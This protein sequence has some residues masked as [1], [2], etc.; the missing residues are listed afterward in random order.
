[1]TVQTATVDIL[2]AV[3][4]IVEKARS[5]HP[6]I[7]ETVVVLGGS[8]ARKDSQVHGHFAPRSWSKK[9]SEEGEREL[10]GEIFLSGESLSRGSVATLG[11]IL[12]ELSHAYNFANNVSDTSNGNRYHN[13]KFKERAESFGLTL[14]KAETIGWS[15]TTVPDA[16]QESYKTELEALDK[17]ITVHRLGTLDLSELG[18]A[19][20]EKPKPKK[21]K[22]QCPSCAE[23]VV[24]T[25]KFWELQGNGSHELGLDYGAGIICRTHEEEYEIFVEGGANN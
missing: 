6:G 21:Y 22:M 3:N 19:E 4:A 1:M 12:H 9:K 2:K 20:P 25:K 23:P 14:E 10:F 11:T 13:A 18:I 15:V 16:T 24:V 7:P 17:A 5:R 8:G